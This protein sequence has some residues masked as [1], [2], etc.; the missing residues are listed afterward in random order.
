[1]V[2]ATS[3]EESGEFSL[4]VGLATRTAGILTQRVKSAG[5]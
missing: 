5:Y 2:T 4:E 3:V 1:M